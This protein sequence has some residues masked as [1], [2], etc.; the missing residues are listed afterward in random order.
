MSSQV[1]SYRLLTDE[2]LILRQKALPGESDNQTAQRLMRECLG[3]STASTNSP[4]VSTPSLDERIESVVEEKMISFSA[5]CNDL[6]SR[7]QGCIQSLQERVDELNSRLEATE[8]TVEVILSEPTRSPQ[9]TAATAR[10]NNLPETPQAISRR[11]IQAFSDKQ[12][13]PLE[14]TQSE[15]AKRLG[16]H[17]SQISR[18][19]ESSDFENWTRERDPDA[20]AWRYEPSSK[21]YLAIE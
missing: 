13:V 1:I 21:K 2:V 18:N 12:E 4:K 9:D 14:L 7:L 20:I 15:L 3:L 5:N 6:L 11:V 16:C 17:K 8:D 19:K 10:Q